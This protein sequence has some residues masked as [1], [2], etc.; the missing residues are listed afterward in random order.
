MRARLR[1]RAG[2]VPLFNIEATLGRS[3]LSSRTPG[4]FL[5]FFL[6]AIG[7]QS[8]DHAVNL[9]ASLIDIKRSED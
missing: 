7:I 3:A 1:T 6:L 2:H 8:V 4:N 9:A 5:G